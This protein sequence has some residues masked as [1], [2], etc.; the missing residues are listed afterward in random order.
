MKPLG[1]ENDFRVKVALMDFG[2]TH[3]PECETHSHWDDDGTAQLTHHAPAHDNVSS[4]NP[5]RE[6]LKNIVQDSCTKPW[7]YLDHLKVP[8]SGE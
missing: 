5:L 3:R 6:V 2:L 7:L 1:C 4:E 8:Q